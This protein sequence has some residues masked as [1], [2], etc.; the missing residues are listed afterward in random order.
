MHFIGKIDKGKIGEYRNKI[1]SDNVVLT[2]ERKAHIYNNHPKDYEKIIR[3]YR[4][5]CFEP[6]RN[7]RRCEK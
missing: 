2:D 4:Q 1:V 3:Q 5:S 6:K 7:I